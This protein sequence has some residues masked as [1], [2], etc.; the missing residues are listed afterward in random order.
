[1]NMRVINERKLYNS[2]NLFLLPRGLFLSQPLKPLHKGAAQNAHSFT[3]SRSAP[4]SSLHSPSTRLCRS[5]SRQSPT[6][7]L[8]VLAP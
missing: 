2:P 6:P 4:A 8:C 1:M 3:G 5:S 7:L